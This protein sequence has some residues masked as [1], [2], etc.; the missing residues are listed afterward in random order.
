[1]AIQA[2]DVIAILPKELAGEDIGWA[3]TDAQAIMSDVF[4]ATVALTDVRRDLIAKYLAAHFVTLKY[5]KGWLTAD[6]IG[7]ASQSYAG[8]REA[9][10]LQ[11]TRYGQQAIVMDPT[12][13]LAKMDSTKMGNAEFRVV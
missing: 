11:L 8:G 4:N 13:L 12:G 6:R 5:E 10:G 7:D 2:S 3:L 9:S 1:M